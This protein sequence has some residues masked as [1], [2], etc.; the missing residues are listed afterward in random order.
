M[1][2]PKHNENLK[3]FVR[4]VL[5][6]SKKAEIEQIDSLRAVVRAALT[7]DL[8]EAKADEAMAVIDREFVD[9]NELRVATELEL[10][11][12]LG[13]KYPDIAQRAMKMVAILNAMFE[14]E[15]TLTLERLKTLGKKEVRQYLRELPEM[16]PYI[17]A[18]V[19]LHAFDYAAVPVDGELMSMVIDAD[20]A[21][22]ESAVEEVQRSLEN[23]LKAEE[24]PDFHVG[25]RK[26]IAA[27]KK[28]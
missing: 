28:K 7:Y 22:E 21:D 11:D 6:E 27:K 16:T 24:V 23:I 17:E 1:K 4:K 8:S 12:M 20:A 10:Q 13:E 26:L 9:I 5:K 14:K 15:G 3:S 19:M 25:V 18:Y 2:S